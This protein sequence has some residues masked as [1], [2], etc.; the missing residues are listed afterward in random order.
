M[1]LRQSAFIAACAFIAMVLPQP[2]AASSFMECEAKGVVQKLLPKDAETD[3]VMAEVK[4]NGATVVGGFAGGGM[5][6]PEAIKTVEVDIT[7]KPELKAGDTVELRYMT[8][9]GMG[10]EGPVSSKTWKLPEAE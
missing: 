7:K 8:Y 9:S 2:A 4:V 3:A 1:F 5:P 6:C 10:S